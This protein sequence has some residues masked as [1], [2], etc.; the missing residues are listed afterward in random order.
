[1]ATLS[2]TDKIVFALEAGIVMAYSILF[3]KK[4][5]QVKNKK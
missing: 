1:M 3:F 5:Q 2:K 4:Y